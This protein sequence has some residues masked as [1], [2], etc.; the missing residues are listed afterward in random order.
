MK[1]RHPAQF[2]AP[3]TNLNLLPTLADK[4]NWTQRCTGT[5]NWH[6]HKLTDMNQPIGSEPRLEIRWPGHIAASAGQDVVCEIVEI[7][8]EDT[9][10]SLDPDDSKELSPN[11]M[12]SLSFQSP[13]DPRGGRCETPV[14]IVSIDDGHATTLVFEVPDQTGVRELNNWAFEQ[15]SQGRGTT[16]FDPRRAHEIFDKCVQVS[17]QFFEQQLP[18]VPDTEKETL[19]E[20]AHNA[21]SN[22]QQAESF[23][24]MQEVE[25]VM[26]SVIHGFLEEF[27]YCAGRLWASE[28]PGSEGKGNE[29][30]EE[31][32]L[33]DT[34]SFN[35]W[36]LTVQIIERAKRRGDQL[37]NELTGRLTKLLRGVLEDTP[38]GL[39]GVCSNFHD[40][41]QNLGAGRAT[42]Q[43]L[44]IAFEIEIV[45]RLDDLH[46]QLNTL[47]ESAGVKAA[48]K[49]MVVAS[50]P[51]GV[52]TQSISAAPESSGNVSAE[53]P[54]P[55]TPGD[56]S[57]QNI[58]N[59]FRTAQTLIQLRREPSA[60]PDT[61]T[62][63][64]HALPHVVLEALVDMDEKEG[65]PDTTLGVPS[66]TSRVKAHLSS[67]DIEPDDAT[68]D[69]LDLVSD[70][71]E[72]MLS[73]PLVH[74]EVTSAISRLSLSL[75]RGAVAGDAFFAEASHP[76][77]QLLDALALVRA[78][79]SMA[80]SWDRI[81][82]ALVPVTHVTVPTRR[83]YAKALS[84]IAPIAERRAGQLQQAIDDAIEQL[85]TQQQTLEAMTNHGT[86]QE[87][88]R[89]GILGDSLV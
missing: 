78:A 86:G 8:L 73:D 84:V 30:P 74:P 69:V 31:L 17:R 39:E 12:V 29:L 89:A 48:P 52:Q 60:S 13:S 58:G 11:S 27:S 20:R 45:K 82:A 3:D 51:A 87:V 22:T 61:A 76:A 68:N 64:E 53:A 77:R 54:S 81:N 1:I 72:S 24:V 25:R 79:Q 35:D 85:T 55:E 32:S 18:A 34:G 36:L 37:Q 40:S 38:F 5:S 75:S 2:S 88:N 33:I 15:R 43:A 14:Q 47:L 7:G 26:P 10:V 4:Q 62:T 59:G 71:V 67:V 49:Q 42:R 44:L 9:R 19:F 50:A 63:T 70:L 83:E 41:M 16:E 6:L 23:D 65:N 21:S 46:R 80:G 28:V 66:L 57:N 56:Q